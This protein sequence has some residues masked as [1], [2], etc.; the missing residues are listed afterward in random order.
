MDAP[1]YDVARRGR[2]AARLALAFAL[3]ACATDADPDPSS[4]DT[5]AVT[6]D[7]GARDTPGQH[8]DLAPGSEVALEGVVTGNTVDA[9][10]FPDDHDEPCVEDLGEILT[11]DVDGEELTVHY[12][13]GEWPPCDNVD[14][15]YDGQAARVGDHVS[16]VAEVV[17][18]DHHSG[19]DLDTCGAPDL[20]IDVHG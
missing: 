10:R 3:T 5:A 13:G 4:S 9:C 17:D 1:P 20:R 15:L 18:D 2:A 19:A 16:V 12:G 8:L 7:E 11:I 6:Q 14:A